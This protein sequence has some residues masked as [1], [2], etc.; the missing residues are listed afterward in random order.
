MTAAGLEPAGSVK[1]GLPVPIALQGVY[2]VSTKTDSS[3][4]GDISQPCPIS[5]DAIETLLFRRPGLT[6]DGR[7]PSPEELTLRISQ[8]WLPDENVVYI[9]LATR[10]S[11]RIR[12]YY[13][14]PLGARRPHAGG[15]FLK[16][17]SIIEDLTVH[18]AT[19]ERPN[20]A[21]SRMIEAFC[22]SVSQG[23]LSELRDPLHPFPF[24]NLE[25]PRGTRK[26][27]GIKGAKESLGSTVGLRSTPAL[28]ESDHSEVTAE[29]GM[30]R[31]GRT[32]RITRA[33]TQA[34][35]IRIPRAYKHLFPDFIASIDVELKGSR[36]NARYNPQMGPPERS[37]VLGIGKEL[38]RKNAVPDQHFSMIV[39][40]N[41]LTLT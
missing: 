33:D 7:R 40:G 18:F 36:T 11:Q 34:G 35:K 13:R 15:W 29:P 37:G 8:F 3:V 32:Q 12:A 30:V 31:T 22:G 2:V 10:L 41:K 4:V 38:L 27:H 24:A 20:D 21:E 14:T 1:W 23:S 6:L 16:L 5:V 9:G 19:C 17:L 25:W 26:N 28:R 39:N